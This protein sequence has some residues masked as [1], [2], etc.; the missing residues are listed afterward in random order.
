MAVIPEIF[1]GLSRSDPRM[2][3]GG[4]LG[5]KFQPPGF[6]SVAMTTGLPRD[7][8]IRPCIFLS[9]T[10][11]CCARRSGSVVSASNLGPAGRELEP[12][13]VHPRC[14]LRQNT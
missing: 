2:H 13:L 14:V 1:L 11:L 8:Q 10:F 9:S 7:P 5:S 3:R 6:N 12:W 4:S